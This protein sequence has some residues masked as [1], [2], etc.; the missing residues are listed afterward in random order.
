MFVSSSDFSFLVAEVEA[1]AVFAA[2]GGRSAY[3]VL[4]PV[5]A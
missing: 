2:F 4:K 1:P 3:A 5:M